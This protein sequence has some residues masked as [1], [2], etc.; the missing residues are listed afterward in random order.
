MQKIDPDQLT[1]LSNTKVL[2]E[3]EHPFRSIDFRIR[4]QVTEPARKNQTFKAEAIKNLIII[5]CLAGKMEKNVWNWKIL[6][7]QNNKSLK[8][9]NT[10]QAWKSRQGK[11]IA[12]N[13]WDYHYRLSSSERR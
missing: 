5:I 10:I 2:P 3:Y 9:K 8:D 4:K 6:L 12:E 11:R 13:R 7:R 1:K